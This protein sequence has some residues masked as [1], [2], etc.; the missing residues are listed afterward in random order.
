MKQKKFSITQRLKSFQYAFNGLKI[1]IIEEHNARIHLFAAI[2]VFIAGVIL[3]LS[4]AEWITIT[5]AIGL[6]IALEAINS[7]IENIADFISPEQNPQIKKIKDLS[8]AAVLVVAISSCAVG[9]II[10]VPKLLIL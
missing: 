4:N 10:F 1:L 8:A 2:C 6:V 3:K 7:A 5:F 9:I